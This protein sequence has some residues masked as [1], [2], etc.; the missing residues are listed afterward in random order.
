MKKFCVFCG[1]YPESKNQEH[2]IPRWLIKRT[3]DPGRKARF[4]VD[5]RNNRPK[6]RE[7]AFDAFAFPACT[8]CNT[9]F[10]K[11]E[12]AAQKVIESLLNREAVPHLAMHILLDWLDK[13]R[14]GLWLGYF[15]LD[16]NP[17]EISPKF[18]IVQRMGQ[19]DRSV[20]IFRIDRKEPGISFIGPESPAFQGS[21]TRFALVIND[22]CFLNSSTISLCSRRLGFPH[23]RPKHLRDDGQ[24]E[25]TFEEGSERVMRPVQKDLVIPW[26]TTL[27]QPVFRNFLTTPQYEKFFDTA[28]VRERSMDWKRGYGSVF[29]ESGRTVR[30]YDSKPSLDWL[31]SEAEGPHGVFR[32]VVP[33]VYHALASDMTEGAKIAGPERRRFMMEG[34][35]GF[36]KVHQALLRALH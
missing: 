11:L 12:T 13:V 33:F 4:G 3:G 2:I 21:P 32:A 23:G 22:L 15:Y 20:S 35:A 36:Q 24:L 30:T 7:F 29:L 6:W 25:I 1:K 10:G 16:R 8:R 14:V 34:V 26:A 27:H 19:F 18:H 5:F 9:V 28:W 17:L 31:P